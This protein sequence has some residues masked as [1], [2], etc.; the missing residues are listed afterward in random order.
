MTSSRCKMRLEPDTL[1]R[2][3]AC[4][5]L[6]TGLNSQRPSLRA[7]SQEPRRIWWAA[8]MKNFTIVGSRTIKSSPGPIKETICSIHLDRMTLTWTSQAVK[9]K[10]QFKTSISSLKCKILVKK[11]LMA[12]TVDRLKLNR[13]IICLRWWKAQSNL[14]I[15]SA[16]SRF[17]KQ[18]LKRELTKRRIGLTWWTHSMTTNFW[19]LEMPIC[20]PHT[21]H[22][23]CRNTTT[24]PWQPVSRIF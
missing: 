11:R 19:H 20:K 4:Q 1:R 14:D 9:P 17:L 10:S 16:D 22:L 15:S 21:T 8:W 13:M 7:P 24:S 23:S 2:I 6:S 12:E 5:L 3:W 18:G